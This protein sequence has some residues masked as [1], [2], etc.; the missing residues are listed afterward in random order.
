MSLEKF[1][2]F[3]SLSFSLSLPFSEERHT[4]HL[5]YS[6]L[7]FPRLYLG[8]LCPLLPLMATPTLSA[9]EEI[10]LQLKQGEDRDRPES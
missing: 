8:A 5:Q 10:L 7:P 2:L 1:F 6:S 9:I 3:L 4:L